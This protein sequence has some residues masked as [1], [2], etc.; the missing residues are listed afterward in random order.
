VALIGL[1][2]ERRGRVLIKAMQ[3]VCALCFSQ[4]PCSCEFIGAR[5]KPTAEGQGHCDARVLLHRLWHDHITYTRF[6]IGARIARNESGAGNFAARLMKNQ[7]AIGAAFGQRFGD[8][9]GKK[10]T[11][12]LKEHIDGA[13]AIVTATLNGKHTKP[14]VKAWRKNAE[15]IADLLNK[16]SDK[17]DLKV[18]NK[19]L[20]MHLDHTLKEAQLLT[21]APGSKEDIANYD[22]I[23]EDVEAMSDFIWK[24]L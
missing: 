20:T 10:L 9:V 14:L 3:D 12:L 6:Y 18:A 17:Y 22:A 7:E 19:V 16:T 13:A 2:E 24:G 15:E 23:I 11:K 21:E 5:K 1:L 8:K 4:D